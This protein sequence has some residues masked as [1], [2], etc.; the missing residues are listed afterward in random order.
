M[1]MCKYKSCGTNLESNSFCT[2]CGE[3]KCDDCASARL[4]SVHKY[5]EPI[6]TELIVT[7]QVVTNRPISRSRPVGLANDPNGKVR[8]RIH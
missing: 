3:P 4:S 1:D 8:D 6:V 2:Q 5:C 7:K